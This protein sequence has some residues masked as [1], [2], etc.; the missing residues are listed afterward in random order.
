EAWQSRRDQ[1]CLL[2]FQRD[3]RVI[4]FLA[5]TSVFLL[6]SLLIVS[7]V[8]AGFGISP[9]AIIQEHLKPGAKVTQ[10]INLSRS[11]PN[12]DLIILVE[13]D[14]GEFE[15]WFEFEPAKSFLFP[16]GEERTKV[17]VHISIPEDV[18]YEKYSGYIRIKATPK[19]K[20]QSGVAVIKGARMDVELITTDI[21]LA[22]LII[23][24]ITIE[25]IEGEN[26]LEV[27]IKAENNGNV[28]TAP[29]K[30]VVEISDLA[31]RLL[32]NIE[33]DDLETIAP[34]QT[35]EITAKLK[36]E[37]GDGEYFANAQIWLKDKKLREERL[38]FK[39][40]GRGEKELKPIGM[41][42]ET[43]QDKLAKDKRT[44]SYLL[45]LFITI[46]LIIITIVWAIRTYKNR[47]EKENKK[48]KTT[49]LI[50]LISLLAL[51]SLSSLVTFRLYK[52]SQEVFTEEIKGVTHQQ[53]TVTP[54]P[55]KVTIFPQDQDFNPMVVS[56]DKGESRYQIYEK[57]DLNSKIIY[58]AIE[59]E[60][61]DV[62]DEMSQWYR[63]IL[64][65]GT[66]GWLP[67]ASVVRMEEKDLLE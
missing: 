45:A 28:P 46:I 42:Q 30:V 62:I 56:N 21:D 54:V 47:N 4:P 17:K 2:H 52:K 37:L 5:M 64:S 29:S 12:E 51:S 7:P 22:Q 66:D 14:L 67:K 36:T 35:K 44:I 55:P 19:E 43:D 48:K 31:N 59:G 34:S 16:Q 63:V 41:D 11:D 57:P 32:E 60:S 15:Q 8:F 13:P 23:R 1:Y 18:A 10:E 65:D 26:P 40:T 49:R 9:A 24:A 38:V 53:P 58:F 27:V 25:D 39:I 61:F 33:T 20:N 50:I 6:F 3:R